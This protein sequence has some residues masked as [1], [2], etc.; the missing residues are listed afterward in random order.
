M[1][2]YFN[3]Q[4]GFTLIELL[5]VIVIIGLLA[6]IA[7]PKFAGVR[8]DA[9]VAVTKSN[10]KSLQTAVERYQLDNGCYPD[11][12]STLISAGYI[13]QKSCMIPT[14]TD[15]YQFGTSATDFLVY[16]SV[17][18]VYATSEGIQDDYSTYSGGISPTAQTL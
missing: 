15:P 4:M 16:D 1:Y 2:K 13:K 14:K 8:D 3:R 12:L 10:L 11:Q 9:N 17:H 7:L 5:V 18:D 6:A